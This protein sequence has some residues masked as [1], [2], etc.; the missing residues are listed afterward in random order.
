MNADHVGGVAFNVVVPFNYSLSNDGNVSV[1][2]G[3]SNVYVQDTITKTLLAGATESVTLTLSGVPSGTSYAIS[4]STCS[5][6]CTSTIT[7]TIGPSTPVGTHTITVTGAPLSKTTSFTLRVFANPFNV[8]CS[9]SPMPALLGENVTWTGTVNG[10]VSPYTY[11]WFGT[12][13]PTSPAPSTNPYTLRYTTIGPK[14]AM[15][16]V[17]DHDGTQSTCPALVGAGGSSSFQ[18]NFNPAFEEF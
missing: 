17:T 2:K 11:S 12:N 1:T 15:L 6:T 9:V 14:I 18:V 4:N 3:S 7:F 10:G 16:T 5:P 8:V 13:I